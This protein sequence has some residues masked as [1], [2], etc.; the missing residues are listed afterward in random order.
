[1]M[2]PQGPCLSDGSND[3]ARSSR[4]D[5]GKASCEGLVGRHFG[6]IQGEIDE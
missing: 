4:A 3:A 5:Q 2:Q 6:R 1:M